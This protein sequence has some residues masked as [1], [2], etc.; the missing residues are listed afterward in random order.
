ML[1]RN[2]DEVNTVEWGAGTSSR[3][4]VE[5]DGMG[6]S[7]T[8]TVVRKGTRS[9]LEYKRHLEACYCVAG[10]GAV[11]DMNG[12]IHPIR[13]GVLYALDKHDPHYLIGGD[14]EDMRLICVFTPPLHG[15]EVHDL[16]NGGSSAY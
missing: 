7:V 13:P 8:E 2:V 9:L 15:H 3:L 5:R 6:Y 12:E 11:E 10:S 4:L 14:D 1:I 16:A